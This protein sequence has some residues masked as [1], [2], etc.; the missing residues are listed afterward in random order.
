MK[1][2]LTGKTA[3]V[4]GSTSGIGLGIARTLHGCGANMVFLGRDPSGLDSVRQAFPERSV[5]C[6]VDIAKDADIE[7]CI[8]A[9]VARFGRIDIL[10]N[11][12]CT[13][14]DAGL[15]STREQWLHTLNI[16][17]VGGAIFLQ[18][19]LPHLKL[20]RGVVVNIGSTGGKFG[21]AGRALYPA[22][23]AAILQL[24]K[25][26]AVTLA[27]FGIRVVSVSPAWTWSPAMAAIAGSV[28]RADSVAAKL[29]P[30]GRAGRDEEVGQVVAF[31]C[32]DLA[33]FMTGADVAVDGGF[34]SLGPDQ[35]RSPGHWFAASG[36]SI[37]LNP[38]MAKLDV[39]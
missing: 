5:H 3:I 24:T 11:N 28:E 30:L 18:K 39:L 7:A 10:V 32:S 38:E 23:K 37:H 1:I 4:T 29:H 2:D 31:L 33:G 35:G 12:A 21:A 13:Y 27:P 26:E 16:N 19:C 6:A 17:L 9:T 36:S 25:N 14:A 15:D 22:S 20:H 34:S 8:A